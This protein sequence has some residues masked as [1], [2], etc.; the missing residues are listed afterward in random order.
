MI[1]YHDCEDL[2]R[3][4][5]FHAPAQ[6]DDDFDDDH[7]VVVVVGLVVVLGPRA[8]VHLSR[9]V[10]SFATNVGLEGVAFPG[11]HSTISILDVPYA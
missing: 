11:I 7:A 1:W 3:A 2:A 4:N 5:A 10:K 6:D 9:N 8:C